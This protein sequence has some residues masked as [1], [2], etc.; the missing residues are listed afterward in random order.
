MKLAPAGTEMLGRL[1]T[2]SA[3]EVAR[4]RRGDEEL[5]CKRLLPQHRD[6]PAARLA[7]VREARALEIAHHRALPALREVGSDAEGPFLLETLV[8]GASLRDVKEHWKGMVPRRLALHSAHQAALVLSALHA[9]TDAKGPVELVHGDLSPD[10]VRLG[11]RGEIRLLDLGNAR[12][13]GFGPELETGARE[14]APYVAPEVARGEATSSQRT[15][16]YALA[17]TIAWLLLDGE[18]PLTDVV[19]EAALLLTI[20]EHGLDAARLAPLPQPLR[21]TLGAMIAFDPAARSSDVARL[22][23]VLGA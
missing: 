21:E 8:E 6:S 13:R 2:G 17:A 7:M 22:A 5:A 19:D 4:V 3:C 11:A 18:S 15:D 1:G 9:L 10:N 20:G 14:A 16:V 12:F 23:E